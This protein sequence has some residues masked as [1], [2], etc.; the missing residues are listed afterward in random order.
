MNMDEIMTGINQLSDGGIQ[1]LQDIY[2]SGQTV[3]IALIVSAVV[4]LLLC[5]FGL[6]LYRVLAALTGL[7]LGIVIGTVA[8]FGIGLS[9]MA[10]AG[11]IIGCGIV[12]AILACIFYRVGLFFWAF[13]IG[14][15]IGTMIL[16][17][18]TLILVLICL[19]IGLVAAILT[20]IFWRPLVVILSAVCG[21]ISAGQAIVEMLPLENNIWITL[22]VC[23]VL[24]VLGMIVQFMMKSREVGK[25]ERVYSEKFKANASM[26]TEV[27]KARRLLDDEEESDK[28]DD[29]VEYE[30]DDDIEYFDDDS[31]EE[32]DDDIT[33]LD[34]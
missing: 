5:F 24:A 7:V 12:I 17:P 15:S 18:S 11:V 3:L 26:E 4:G 27:E 34:E 20:A 32:L 31:D 30:E 10:I 6:K 21:G 8:A 14:T 1:Q 13:A 22:A 29:D 2:G 19:A 25:K 9:G 23:A 28:E 16:K 33:F